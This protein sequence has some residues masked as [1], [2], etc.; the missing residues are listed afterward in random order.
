MYVAG[1]PCEQV[2]R[3]EETTHLE[4]ALFR[5]VIKATFSDRMFPWATAATRKEQRKMFALDV[6][7]RCH[8][9]HRMYNGNVT[10][11]ASLM[12]RFIETTLDCYVGDCKKSRYSSVICSGGKKLVEKNQC[13]C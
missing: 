8:R 3:Q 1:M 6:K 9:I 12:P 10:K 11:V 2:D 5:N 7:V 13:T 4:Q